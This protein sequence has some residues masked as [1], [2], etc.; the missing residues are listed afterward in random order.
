MKAWKVAGLSVAA[1]GL[2]LLLAGCGGGGSASSSTGTNPDVTNPDTTAG[3]TDGTTV[4]TTSRL[5]EDGATAEL[6]AADQRTN[7]TAALISDAGG[8][9]PPNPPVVR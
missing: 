3:G 4:D 5:F 8:D 6:V 7:P 9:V 1:A 2:A